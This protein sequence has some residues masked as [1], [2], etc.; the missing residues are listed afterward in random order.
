MCAVVGMA[1]AIA[2]MASGCGRLW[3]CPQP[4]TWSM[5]ARWPFDAPLQAELGAVGAVALVALTTALHAPQR[6][7]HTVYLY[8]V[9]KLPD[10]G[11]HTDTTDHK[12]DSARGARHATPPTSGRP[13]AHRA[14]SRHPQTFLCTVVGRGVDT[15]AKSGT[16]SSHRFTPWSTQHVKHQRLDCLYGSVRH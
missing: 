3:A 12:P 6:I 8:S 9:Y 2:C 11:N 5:G 14:T 7:S 10:E 16:Q 4:L 1:T 13:V 15:V